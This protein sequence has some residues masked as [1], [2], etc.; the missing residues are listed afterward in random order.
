MATQ[1][2]INLALCDVLDKIRDKLEKLDNELKILQVRQE[3]MARKLSKFS[4]ENNE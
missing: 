2:E 3:L 1:E 4:D